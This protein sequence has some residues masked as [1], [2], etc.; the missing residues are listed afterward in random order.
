MAQIIPGVYLGCVN[1]ATNRKFIIENN[2]NVIYSII[3]ENEMNESIENNNVEKIIT[4]ECTVQLRYTSSDNNIATHDVVWKQYEIS[5]TNEEQIDKHFEAIYID[6][7]AN[8]TA[9]R[10]V[11]VH[12]K[13]GISRSATI[14]A[15]FLMQRNK[16]SRK[17]SIEFISKIKPNIDPND[18]FM[19][20]LKTLEYKIMH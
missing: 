1:T 14:I 15:A 17:E 4:N 11:L 7:T 9:G 12:C 2:I 5:D 13:E 20:K 10:N 6:I 3:T 19:D 16:I 18:G 8:I